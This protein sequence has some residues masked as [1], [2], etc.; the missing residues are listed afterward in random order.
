VATYYVDPENGNDAADGLSESTPWKLIPG[1]TGANAVLAG[2][3]IN[4]KN[5]TTSRLRVIAPANNL[6][7]R[8]YGKASNR[9]SFFISANATKQ[10]RTVFR[11]Q[12]VHEGMWT[13]DGSDDPASVGVTGYFTF[14]TRSGCVL[15]DCEIIDNI[16]NP[17]GLY[18][19][20]R[21]ISNKY[22][23]HKN[24]DKEFV[25]DEGKKTIES[26]YSHYEL[27]DPNM[28]F[29]LIVDN[30][31]NLAQEKQDM[32]VLSQLE[33]IN[34]WSRSYCRLQIAKHWKWS[35]LNVIQQAADSEKQQFDIRGRTIV[36]KIK[37]SLGLT[38]S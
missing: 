20:C 29:L 26:V 8:G 16:Y 7:Y 25:H 4:V 2:D 32:R 5:G 10:Q 3:T 12:G 6:T 14:F 9:L 37:P 27:K 21:S 13:L 11:E 30:L 33:T 15:E 34:L 18:K 22:G 28:Q 17:T 38:N 19:W 31:N 1:Q 36:E 23:E 35:I 24:K